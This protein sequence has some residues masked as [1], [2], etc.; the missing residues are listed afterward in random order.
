[1]R[2]A[3]RRLYPVAN[4]AHPGLLM[5]RGLMEHN[6]ENKEAKTAHIRKICGITSTPFY[7]NAYQRWRTAT[8][9]PLRFRQLELAL[10]S[11]LF[12]GLTGGGMLETGCAISHS[13]GMPYIPGS[14]VKGVVRAQVCGSPFAGQHPEVIA[15]LF[16]AEADPTPEA[17]YPQG[18]SGLVTFHDA[19]W[20]PGSAEHPLVEEIVTTHH[21]EYYGTEGRTPATDFDSPV[22][23]AQIAV[24]GNFLFVLEGPLAWLELAQRMLIAALSKRGIGAKTRT[25]YGLFDPAPQKPAGPVCAWVDETIARLAQQNNNAKPD[26]VLRSKGLA[27]EWAALTDPAL[28]AEALEDIRSRWQAKGWW[29][30][31]P[32]KSAKQARAIYDG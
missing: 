28:K 27:G 10:E 19:W 7:H 29:D 14:S 8:A 25:G 20:V 30:E 18:L 4:D 1:M 22:P 6:E 13:Y 15:E 32:G 21:L 11:R 31:P 24:Q 23:N 12:I 26:D 5:Q 3:L 16:G 9:D 17:P 2:E